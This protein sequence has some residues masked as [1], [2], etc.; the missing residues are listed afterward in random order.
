MGYIIEID[1]HML[2]KYRTT[3]AQLSWCLTHVLGMLLK[4]LQ[5]NQFFQKRLTDNTR[6]D[7]E[8]DRHLEILGSSKFGT[9]ITSTRIDQKNLEKHLRKFLSLSPP[10][11]KLFKDC[12]QLS[13]THLE[14]S[15]SVFLT[16]FYI[17]WSTT[18]FLQPRFFTFHENHVK[19]HDKPT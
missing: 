6:R 18:T 13:A 15:Q 12:P 14:K 9:K 17:W 19:R 11:T 5:S 8:T 2:S 4:Q 1:R 16:S 10:F 3:L 7:T